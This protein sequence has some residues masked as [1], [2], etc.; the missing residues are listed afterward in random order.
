MDQPTTIKIR[1]R[2]L[3]QFFFAH[4]V[5]FISQGKD[6]LGD[7]VWE[8]ERTPETEFILAEFRH[9]VRVRSERRG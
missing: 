9:G 6:E 3:E 2:N 4:G 8:Y 7:T 5:D 1:S